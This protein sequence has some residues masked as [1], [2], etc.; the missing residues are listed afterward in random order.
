[1]VVDVS[2]DN[3]AVFLLMSYN[4][5]QEK[6]DRLHRAVATGYDVN[7][8]SDDPM[9]YQQAQQLQAKARGCATIA[10]QITANKS[11][12][13]TLAATFKSIRDIVKKVSD[14]VTALPDQ[15]TRDDQMS[16]VASITAYLKTIKALIDGSGDAGGFGLGS[17]SMVV[18]LSPNAALDPTST[19]GA[20]LLTLTSPALSIFG[21]SGILTRKVSELPVPANDPSLV[22]LSDTATAYGVYLS[23]ANGQNQLLYNL[24]RWLGFVSNAESSV[25][26][27]SGSLDIQLTQVRSNQN[28][29]N[30]QAEALTKT[31]LTADSAMLT[32]LDARQQLLTNML[33]A[34]NQRMSAVISLF[35]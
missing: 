6:I 8:A 32:A 12:L 31:D 18:N 20:C 11:K 7:Q 25:G 22:K 10:T 33:A 29:Y 26:A 14:I 3:S 19:N 21:V 17:G 5:N 1:M 30:A 9:A 34:S 4:A 35:R 13:D 2:L 15:P 27:F 24:N 16:A 28:S 23:N